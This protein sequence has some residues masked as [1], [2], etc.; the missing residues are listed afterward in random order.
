ME[1]V[2]LDTD[3]QRLLWTSIL[4]VLA[5]NLTPLLELQNYINSR[6][7]KNPVGYV[8]GCIEKY[9]LP[10]L[11]GWIGREEAF[12]DQSKLG[13]STTTLLG[14]TDGGTPLPVI[15]PR[16]FASMSAFQCRY[17][18]RQATVPDVTTGG[19]EKVTG[20]FLLCSRF[21]FSLRIRILDFNLS[22]RIRPATKAAMNW[23]LSRVHVSLDEYIWPCST[24]A[25][26]PALHYPSAGTPRRYIDP[27]DWTTSALLEV[28]AQ[29]R[30]RPWM[31]LKPDFSYG[32]LY[33]AWGTVPPDT[34]EV[35]TA[36][37]P[38]LAAILTKLKAEI[39]PVLHEE[40]RSIRL[41]R[42]C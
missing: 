28:S 37:S 16:V 2:D 7:R 20:F 27:V 23:Y 12:G 3:L 33:A 42:M 15:L 35:Y 11:D 25:P 1:L 22:S 6:L 41:L 10:H 14:N 18:F 38:A 32:P 5:E 17:E 40:I 29:F 34:A 19:S 26:S 4:L 8:L 9:V 24:G 13:C 31:L 21:L 36:R 30:D 39:V